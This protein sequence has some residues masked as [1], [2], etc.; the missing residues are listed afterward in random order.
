MS[1]TIFALI[2]FGCAD[3]GTMC[4]RLSAAPKH[5][6]SQVLCEADVDTALASEIAV[7]A[8]YPTVIARCQSGA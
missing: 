7:R 2:L 3:D 4:E 8:D 1:S 5:Y 6:D